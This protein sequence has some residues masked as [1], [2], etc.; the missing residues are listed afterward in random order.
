VKKIAPHAV[1]KIPGSGGKMA[2]HMGALNALAPATPRRSPGVMNAYARMPAF[3]PR[4]GAGPVGSPPPGFGMGPPVPG[5][6]SAPGAAGAIGPLGA[7]MRP[8]RKR[9]GLRG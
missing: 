4:G 8:P 2:V 3:G 5:P 9:G 1:A 7:T 6:L